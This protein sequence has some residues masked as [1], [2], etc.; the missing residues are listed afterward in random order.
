V[1]EADGAA[2]LQVVHAKLRAGLALLGRAE[3]REAGHVG[4]L[5][6]EL[7]EATLEVVVG[8]DVVEDGLLGFE[9]RQVAPPTEG[10]R[11][12]KPEVGLVEL[13]LAALDGELG[14]L[15]GEVLGDTLLQL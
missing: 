10:L 2:R 6:Q 13:D 14:D 5:V 7:R 9:R 4:G 1:I 12:G 3:R 8:G 15:A 11:L